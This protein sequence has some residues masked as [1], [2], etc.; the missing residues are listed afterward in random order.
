MLLGIYSTMLYELYPLLT[1]TILDS[2]EAVYVVNNKSLFILGTFKL[3][4]ELKIVNVGI[5]S[6]TI[7]GIGDCLI[8]NFFNSDR[9]LKTEDLLLKN[10]KLVNRFYITV[11]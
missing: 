9:G 2:R 4:T 7:R 10:V 1:S 8:K 11:G 6:L 5:E 3:I